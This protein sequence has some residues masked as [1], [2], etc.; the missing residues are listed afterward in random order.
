MLA[1]SQCLRVGFPSRVIL[2]IHSMTQTSS[3]TCSTFPN[4]IFRRLGIAELYFME[5]VAYFFCLK[6]FMPVKRATLDLQ[7]EKIVTEVR[8][9]AYSMGLVQVGS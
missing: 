8:V 4:V 1:I 6:H 5:S 3:K 9:W 7:P 2:P